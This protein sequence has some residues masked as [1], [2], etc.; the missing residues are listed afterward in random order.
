M[1]LRIDGMS[2]HRACWVGRDDIVRTLLRTGLDP[3][4]LSDEDERSVGRWDF[5]PGGP[6]RPLFYL[7]NVGV[8][9]DAQLNI[10]RLLLAHGAYVIEEDLGDFDAER[11]A[12]TND[13]S[14]EVRAL[15]AA[16]VVRP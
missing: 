1:A 6:E 10:A 4:V 5:W 8:Y 13:R 14:A 16:R 9:R 3:N 15:L 7:V 12:A 2:I 11:S